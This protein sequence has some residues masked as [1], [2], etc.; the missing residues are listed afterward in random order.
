MAGI[1][2]GAAVTVLLVSSSANVLAADKLMVYPA[3]G[4]S[5]QQLADDRYECH[6]AAVARSGFDPSNPPPE[7]PNGPV[8][9]RVPDNEREGAG[10]KGTIAGAIAGAVVGARDD[11][12]LEGAITGATVGTAVGGVVEARGERKARESAEEQARQAIEG[13]AAAREALDEWRAD[14]RSALAL[15]LEN[16]GYVVR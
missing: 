14:Y 9:V 16:R 12:A 15:C 7:P 3:E 11:D 2:L 4:Q 1:R 6:V 10:R 13:R 5:E 8:S